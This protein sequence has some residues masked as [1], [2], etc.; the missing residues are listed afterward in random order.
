M[1]IHSGEKPYKCLTC[2]KTF[3]YKTHFVKHVREGH[4]KLKSCGY[5]DKKFGL[6]RA[7]NKKR[8]DHI[9]KHFERLLL[10]LKIPAGDV[11]VPYDSW[12]E[13][14]LKKLAKKYKIQE[15][16]GTNVALIRANYV[17]MSWI[18]DPF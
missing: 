5:C 8:S 12:R 1:R 10:K 11:V 18:T 2:E 14:K 17:L 16:W 7:D 13:E 9:Q 15:C 6:T 4:I 3:R